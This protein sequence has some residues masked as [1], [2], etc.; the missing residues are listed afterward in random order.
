MLPLALVPITIRAA[1]ALACLLENLF[2]GRAERDA[3]FWF[4]PSKSYPGSKRAP[5]FGFPGGDKTRFGTTP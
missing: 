5:H 4:A 1:F 2:N 3:N